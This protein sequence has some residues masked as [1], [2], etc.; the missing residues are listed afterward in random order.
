MTIGTEGSQITGTPE[1]SF[2]YKRNSLL[3]SKTTMTAGTVRI[4]RFP[5]F[6]KSNRTSHSTRKAHFV[7]VQSITLNERG[8]KFY[9]DI[10]TFRTA[11]VFCLKG[12]LG[13][14]SIDRDKYR[15][16]QRGINMF[17]VLFPLRVGQLKDAERSC[18]H[19]CCYY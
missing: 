9:S 8:R 13:R 12:R 19:F 10:R 2:K 6:P 14:S 4:L 15:S 1:F 11:A 17:G 5:P 18:S 16:T 7:G 3:L